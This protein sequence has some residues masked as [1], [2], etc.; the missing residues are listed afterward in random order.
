MAKILIKNGRVWD[1]T[2]FRNC[3]VLT[4]GDKIAKIEPRI[5]DEKAFV[6]DATGK[7]VSAGLVDL[8][9]HLRGISSKRFGIC[10]EASAFPFGVTAVADCGAEYGNRALLDS[11]QLKNMVFVLIPIKNNRADFTKADEKIAAYGEKAVGIKIY[12]DTASGEVRD[13]TPLREISAF[14]RRRGLRVMVHSSNQPVGMAELLPELAAG[15][16]ITHAYHGGIHSAAEDGFESLRLAK[17]RGVVVDAG[18]AGHVHTDFSVLKEGIR[19]GVL[20]DTI[21]TDI[22][23]ASAY[24]RGGRYGMTTCMSMAKEAG[25]QE[26]DIFRAVTSAPAKIL[27]KENEWGFLKEGCKA[28]LAVFDYGKEGFDLT[29]KEGNRLSS[30]TGYRCILTVADGQILY[31][32]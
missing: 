2:F 29:D 32:D 8:H 22:T 17:M 14:A 7:I 23:C 18:F 28:D 13:L 10:G 12:F 15:D 11:F 3:D 27:G 5:E 19:K 30:E 26:E 9:V 6:F 24:M 4:D 16:I 31:K 25:M 20:P 1:G 21:S